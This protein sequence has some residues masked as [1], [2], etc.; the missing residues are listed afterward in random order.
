MITTL[1]L[2]GQVLE[3][4]ARHQT[5]TAIRE[6]LQPAPKTARVVRDGVDQDVPLDEVRVGDLCRVRPGERIP[7]DGVVV[8]GRTAVDEAMVTGEPLPAEKEP[9]SRV[10]GGTINATGSIV[11]QGRSCRRR[12]A[13][14]RKS[15]AWSAKRSERA[16]RFSASLIAFRRGLF[17]RSS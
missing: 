2:L 4:R 7:V 15:S 14:S 5:G 3:L 13:C 1:V 11:F 9:G 8:E 16:R 12:D 10:T 6:L 17:P